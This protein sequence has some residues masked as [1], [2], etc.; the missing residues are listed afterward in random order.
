MESPIGFVPMAV[1]FLAS[2]GVGCLA[3]KWMIELVSK[4]KLVWFALYC[5][6]VGLLCI[7]W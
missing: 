3:C 2:F 7:L 5:V 6:A 4:G 1:G